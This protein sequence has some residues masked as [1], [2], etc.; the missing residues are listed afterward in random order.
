MFSN[1]DYRK[2]T[3]Q[4]TCF[5]H[6]WRRGLVVTVFNITVFIKIAHARN[7]WNEQERLRKMR[8]RKITSIESV[9]D[10]HIVQC[11]ESG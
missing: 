3:H 1:V 11:L 9:R 7:Q 2:C 10:E 4:I 6:F 8:P 5:D